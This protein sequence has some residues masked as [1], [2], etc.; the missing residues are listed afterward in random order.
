MLTPA[1]WPMAPR[2][3]QQV[4]VAVERSCSLLGDASALLFRKVETRR[5]NM[6]H[7]SILFLEQS[8]PPV[9]ENSKWVYS[10]HWRG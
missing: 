9:P 8:I 4:V 6:L 2:L 10:T 3:A 1:L 7:I 5:L